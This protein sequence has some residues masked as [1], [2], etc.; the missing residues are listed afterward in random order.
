MSPTDGRGAGRRGDPEHIEH[1]LLARIA[2]ERR[3]LI[4]QAQEL[5]RPLRNVDRV[6]DG[7]RE[8]RRVRGM[9]L[10]LLPGVV[11]LWRA[12]PLI[13]IAI[14]A[15]AAWKLL[16]RVSG[17]ISGVLASRPVRNRWHG[18]RRDII[19]ASSSRGGL[20][21]IGALAGALLARRILSPRS[22]SPD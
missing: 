8:M 22:M 16:R 4:E 14:R 21:L 17:A 9:S 13:R 11:M 2:A 1:E 15:W 19:G 10:L 12:R 5:R 20:L 6:G 7:L 18:T 3:E